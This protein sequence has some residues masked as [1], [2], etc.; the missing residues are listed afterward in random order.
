MRFKNRYL[1]VQLLFSPP[2]LIVPSLTSYVLY[3]DLRHSLLT[4]FGEFGYGQTT[5][6]LQV[7][8]LNHRTCLAI[9]R[10]PRDDV[11]VV[12]T[13]MTM[14]KEV[15]GEPC[16]MRV[17]HVG[18]TIRACQKAA[19]RWTRLVLLEAWRKRVADK[20]GSDEVR[21]REA[22]KAKDEADAVMAEAEAEINKL[23]T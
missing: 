15:G 20:R 4:N 21:E 17:V 6:S 3:R 22:A 23:E 10:A 12:R 8:Y 18:G 1:L 2:S 9:V 16:V 13:A 7:K 5:A 11:D 19:V 14:M